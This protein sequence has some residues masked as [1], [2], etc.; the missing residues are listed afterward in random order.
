MRAA[1]SDS[2]GFRNPAGEYVAGTR[3]QPI[4]KIPV[5]AGVRFE[6]SD[7]RDR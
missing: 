2:S 3:H 4:E 6:S 1:R 7:Y 5:D